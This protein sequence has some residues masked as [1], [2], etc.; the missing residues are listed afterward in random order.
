MYGTIRKKSL[1]FGPLGDA[2][3]QARHA[4]E[5]TKRAEGDQPQAS[6]GH[7][8]LRGAEEGCEGP[9]KPEP[10]ATEFPQAEVFLSASNMPPHPM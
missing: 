10:Q 2:S 7:R 1:K 6:R 3:P 8:A 5:W 9:A 4:Q